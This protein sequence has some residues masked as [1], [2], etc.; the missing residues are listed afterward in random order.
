MQLPDSVPRPNPP[1]AFSDWLGRM[2]EASTNW[3][4]DWIVSILAK[5]R[6]SYKRVVGAESEFKEL[7]QE[8]F[9][10]TFDRFTLR[11]DGWVPQLSRYVS[12]AGER[13]CLRQVTRLKR[14]QPSVGPIEDQPALDVED[15]R[16]PDATVESREF[17][18][19]FRATLQ[20]KHL[21]PRDLTVIFLKYRGK[22]SRWIGERM[23]MRTAAVDT[24]F[25]RAKK[26][27]RQCWIKLHGAKSW[28][29]YFPD[30]DQ[31]RDGSGD[32]QGTDFTNEQD[33]DHGSDGLERGIGD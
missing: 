30:D 6:R 5:Y 15:Y 21:K 18:H 19:L 33:R 1:E 11:G 31:G 27:F 26:S 10:S 23:G 17:Q 7:C 32:R 28:N 14:Q 13:Y 25:H 24:W 16:A 2:D 3:V 12:M 29:D 9:A 22:S 20:D 4:I 8:V